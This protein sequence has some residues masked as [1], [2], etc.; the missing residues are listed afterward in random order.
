MREAYIEE[1]KTAAIEQSASVDWRASF[2]KLSAIFEIDAKTESFANSMG[3][4]L[5]VKERDKKINIELLPKSMIVFIK[6]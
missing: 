5:D 6:S 4:K 1:L 3:V 2:D